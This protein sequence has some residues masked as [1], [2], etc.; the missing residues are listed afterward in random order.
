MKVPRSILKVA[1]VCSS[2]L[3]AGGLIAH[4]SGALPWLNPKPAALP[5][6]RRCVPQ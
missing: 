3:L 4:K 1:A 6:G 2:L 5:P